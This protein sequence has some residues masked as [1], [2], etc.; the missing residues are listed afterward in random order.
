MTV[1]FIT[2][3]TTPAS[4][5]LYPAKTFR[6]APIIDFRKVFPKSLIRYNERTGHASIPR[7]PHAAA[8]IRDRLEDM[9][10]R[11]DE[12]FAR[13]LAAYDRLDEI[14]AVKLATD[15]S[16]LPPSKTER[17]FHQSRSMAYILELFRNGYP[18]AGLFSDMG[19]GKTKTA[20]DLFD[21]LEYDKILVIGPRSSV[22]VWHREIRR[23]A[24]RP[25]LVILPDTTV[26]V[27]ER[28]RRAA[29]RMSR[30]TIP[31]VVIANYDMVWREPFASW[32]LDQRWDMII[33]DELH[34]I[35][36]ATGRIS[37]YVATLG[38]R[39]IR[40][41]GLTGTPL[42]HSPLDVWGQFR[43]LDPAI[44]PMS[45]MDFANRYRPLVKHGERHPD[46]ERELHEKIYQIAYRV[47]SDVLQLPEAKH[48]VIMGDLSP[49]A[50]RVYR[51]LE[52]E[53]VADIGAGRVTAR[54]GLARLIRLQQV[55]SGFVGDDKGNV[56]RL[57]NDKEELLYDFLM[58]LHPREPV[59]VYAEF[60]YDLDRIKAVAR[61]TN[62]EYGEIS[63]RRRDIDR[64]RE[65]KID[66][67]GVQI[68]AGAESEDLS[69]ARYAVYYSSGFSL[70]TYQQSLKRL[71][72]PGQRRSVTYYHLVM[73]GTID[74]RKMRYLHERKDLVEA[75]LADLVEHPETE[76]EA[77]V[78][79]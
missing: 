60:L 15:F 9:N 28:T 33:C 1:P 22:Y 64:W 63:G 27:A 46:L 69:R 21:A 7:S 55:T 29:S 4:I 14:Q 48:E 20:I 13:L 24:Q 43:F 16:H 30:A 2:A 61:R 3:K 68:R 44:F 45:F 6:G 66:L 19:T 70:G 41:L 31:V 77:A 42:H 58:D 37:R 34:R 62:R 59:V 51:Q 12:T 47:T 79:I 73:R 18:G 38:Q 10:F 56:H 54:N 40:R 52:R 35:K 26:S 23:H 39:A 5:Y 36:A 25:Y 76:E 67:L 32:A 53:L 75:I 49:E 74:E 57:G 17:W 78:A 11:Y 50:A 71:H 65:G 8:Y 72:R